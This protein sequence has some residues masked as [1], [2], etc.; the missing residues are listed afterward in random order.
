MASE[1]S[2]T[3]P[4]CTQAATRTCGKCLK[5][6][7]KLH[8]ATTG[9]H[10]GWSQSG[11]ELYRPGSYCVRCVRSANRRRAIVYAVVWGVLLLFAVTF[12]M[13]RY[14]TEIMRAVMPYLQ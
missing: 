2:C 3:M 10:N 12:L 13:S 5:T 14:G 11:R 7:C 1:V 9:L 6:V 4:G 8:I